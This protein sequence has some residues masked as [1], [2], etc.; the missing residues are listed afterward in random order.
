M[1]AIE[2]VNHRTLDT[3]ASAIEALSRVRGHMP[4]AEGQLNIFHF[5]NARHVEKRVG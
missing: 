2:I 5:W 4:S 1:K 3:R